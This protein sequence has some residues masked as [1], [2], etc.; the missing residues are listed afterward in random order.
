V[1]YGIDTNGA[2]I[3]AVICEGDA[4]LV[5]EPGKPLP[6]YVKFPGGVIK[7]GETPEQAARREVFEE[8]GIQLGD[9]ILFPLNQQILQKQ[10]GVEHTQYF[11][12]VIVHPALVV[13][14]RHGFV[15]TC[16]DDG[17]HIES[18]CYRLAELDQM[19]DFHPEH[20][21]LIDSLKQKK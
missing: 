18:A 21:E 2:V 16:D 5:R 15:V 20:R 10:R 4:V 6:T 9:H 7:V 11:L 3:V 19:L 1:T 13:A 17:S 14:H 8:T 12:G